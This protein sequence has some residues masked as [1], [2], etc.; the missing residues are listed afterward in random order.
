MLC[1]AL[2]AQIRKFN[3]WKPGNRVFTISIELIETYWFIFQEEATKV[4]EKKESDNESVKDAWDA[5]SSD[6]EPEPPKEAEPTPPTNEIKKTE[7]KSKEVLILKCQFVSFIY[8][9]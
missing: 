4:E 3:N 1:H 2:A 9:L 6:E 7:Q 8:T 5:E